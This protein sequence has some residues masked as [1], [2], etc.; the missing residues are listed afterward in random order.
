LEDLL[1][2]YAMNG[3]HAHPSLRAAISAPCVRARFLIGWLLVV[4]CCAGIAL[5]HA[6]PADVIARVKPSIVAIG[7]FQQL[8]NPQFA[9]R[10][11]GFVVG[12][13]SL[14][15]TNAHVLPA[16]VDSARRESLVVAVPPPD[17]MTDVQARQARAIATDKEYDLVVLQIEGAPLPA[18]PLAETVRV[19]EGETFLFT[20]FPIG[21]VLGLIPATHRAMVSALTPI[22][23]PAR[24]TRELSARAVTRLAGGAY[25]VLQL[26]ATAY[27]GNSGSPLYDEKRGEVVGIVNMVFVKGTKES[28]LTQPSGISYAI[29]VQPLV[30]L[31]KRAAK[32]DR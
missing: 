21:P 17:G 16:S 11:T 25:K 12:D 28:A 10:G 22:V 15:V 30:D 5:C 8:R 27:P 19:R 13:G 29:P 1:F 2:Q 20:G 31:L 6:E 14:V 26:D 3:T 9:F 7:T 18:L 4:M 32:P 24:S 23:I